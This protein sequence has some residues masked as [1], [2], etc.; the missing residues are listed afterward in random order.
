MKKKDVI[1]V[2]IAYKL[3]ELNKQLKQYPLPIPP[4]LAENER[5]YLLL[6]ISEINAQT[7]ILNEVIEF[8]KVFNSIQDGKEK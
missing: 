5:Q 1:E 6:R 3:S 2:A 7:A 4:L 8:L